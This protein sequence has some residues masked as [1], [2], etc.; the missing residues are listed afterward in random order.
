MTPL[1]I[2]ILLWYHGRAEDFERLDAPAV[3]EAVDEFKGPLGML[4]LR[5]PAGGGDYRTYQLTERGRAYINALLMLP[6]PVC[7]WVIP[8]PALSTFAAAG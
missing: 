2:E 5:A 7:H 4:E 6:L 8:A 1:Q 3:R